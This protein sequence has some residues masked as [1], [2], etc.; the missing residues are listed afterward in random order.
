[1]SG[2]DARPPHDALLFFDDKVIDGVRVGPWKYY[3]YV[4]RYYWPTPLDNPTSLVGRRL[5][6]YTYTDP[7]T[8]QTIRLTPGYPLLYDLRIDPGEAYNVVDRHPEVSQRALRTIQDW[9]NAFFANPRGW[10]PP[11]AP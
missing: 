11:A 8:G 5:A 3:R 2:T 9:E 4:D 1:M 6:G 7:R 10:K